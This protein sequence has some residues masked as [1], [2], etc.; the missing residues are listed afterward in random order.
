MDPVALGERLRAARENCRVS[1]EAAAQAIDA[2]RTAIT[3]IEAGR[4]SVS[5]LELSKLAALY[6]RPVSAFFGELEAHAEEDPLVALFR[7]APSLGK[8]SKSRNDLSLYLSL[9]AEGLA[10]QELLERKPR[11]GPPAYDLPPP[12]YTGEAVAQGTDV[13]GEERKRLGLGRVRQPKLYMFE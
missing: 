4:R 8:D 12:R 7:I 13:A 3:Q 2:P 9:C 1:Q 11:S 5:T 10:L 6:K